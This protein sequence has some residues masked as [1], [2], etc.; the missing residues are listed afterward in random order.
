MAEPTGANAALQLVVRFNDTFN[1][2]DVSAM[3]RLMTDD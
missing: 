2:H 3:M 1:A